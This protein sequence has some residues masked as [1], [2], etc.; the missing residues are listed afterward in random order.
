MNRFTG[1]L[2]ARPTFWEGIAR[3]LD[4][5]DTLTEYNISSTPEEADLE[6]LRSDWYAIGQDMMHAVEVAKADM[7]PSP[8]NV[9]EKA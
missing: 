4:F 9:T 8:A 6:A 5:G 1:L 3:I 7:E 2:Y